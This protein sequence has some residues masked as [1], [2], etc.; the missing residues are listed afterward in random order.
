MKPHLS[1][2][3]LFAF[4]CSAAALPKVADYNVLDYGAAGNGIAKDTAAIARAVAAAH[5]AG[6]GTVHFPAGRYLTGSIQLESNI[7]LQID[8]GAVVL[9]SG[10][11]ADSPL[12]PSRWEDT[13]VWEHAPLVYANGKQNIA[14]VGRGTLDGQGRNWWWRARGEGATAEPRRAWLALYERIQAGQRVSKEDFAQA[15]EFLRPSLVQ[16]YGCQNVLV[17]GVTITESPMWM[18]HPLYS[19][20]VEVRGVTFRSD[21]DSPNTDGID[22]DSCRDVRISD[23]FFATGDDCIVIKSGR[24]ADGRRV[25]RPTEH[26]VITNCVMYH[27]HGAIVIGSETSGDVRDVV[28]SNIVSK[29]TDCGIRIKSQRGR[30]GVVENV[31]CDNF[32]IEDSGSQVKKGSPSQAIEIT[33]LYSQMPPEPLSERTPVFRNLAFSH[34]T[35]TNALQVASIEGLPEKAIS[36]LRF[37]DITATGRV[38]F[39]CDH[40]SDVELRD[41]DVSAAS[42]ADFAFDSVGDLVL[43]DVT[44]GCPRKADPVIRL[45]RAAAVVL[46]DS[47]ASAG[48]GT[49]VEEVGEK[50]PNL[51]LVADDLS[52]AATPVATA[53]L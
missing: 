6:G 11:P 41:V 53:G 50:P 13:D 18:L 37:S 47:T 8:A 52:A 12:V 25:A 23:C 10:D 21:I 44:S 3:F 15:A 28:A 27:G 5:A 49:F 39:V 36:G 29:G 35:I 20:N 42:G 4:A 46:R 22:I 38:G 17:E 43:D 34:I 19:D 33:T 32:V 24:D 51:R 1:W 48:T 16:P 26:V 40:A 14:I 7:T 45:E 2:T 9:Y 31:R 30:G